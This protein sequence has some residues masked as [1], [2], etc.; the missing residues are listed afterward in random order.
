MTHKHH[1][2]VAPW[3]G[4]PCFPS[5]TYL[6]LVTAVVTSVGV[7]GGGCH[8]KKNACLC[9]RAWVGKQRSLGEGSHHKTEN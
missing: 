8:D 2:H 4:K 9:G 7:V 3:C 5:Q 1:K 6:R